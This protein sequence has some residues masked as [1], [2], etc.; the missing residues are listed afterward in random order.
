MALTNQELLITLWLVST[1]CKRVLT[2]C[3]ETDVSH[4]VVYG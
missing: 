1:H 2:S 4:G 3:S